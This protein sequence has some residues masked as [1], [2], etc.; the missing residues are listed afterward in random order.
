MTTQHAVQGA[1]L[2]TPSGKPLYGLFPIL[3]TPFT[4]NDVLDLEGLA[5]E[6]RFLNR[7]GVNGM[8]WPVFASSWSTLSEAERMKGAETI[9]SA[10][11]ERRLRLR[12]RTRPGTLLHRFDTLSMPLRMVQMR[13][14]RF[15]QTTAGMSAIKPSSITTALS[16]VQPRCHSSY[17]PAEL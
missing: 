4:P 7:G 12:F 3:Q 2:T 5:A 6:V 15:R 10:G 16:A 11:T 13:L 14:S 1:R 9:L 8:I 17:R